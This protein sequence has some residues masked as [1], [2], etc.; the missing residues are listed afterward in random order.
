[1][2]YLR[3]GNVQQVGQIHSQAAYRD[4]PCWRQPKNS[5]GL[6]LQKLWSRFVEQQG[7]IVDNSW[8]S[9]ACRFK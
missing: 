3:T 9:D 1:M 5:R 7:T 4:N 6:V 8:C 2:V